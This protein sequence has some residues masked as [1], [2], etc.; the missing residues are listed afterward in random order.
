MEKESII[1]ATKVKVY[2]T[3][4]VES[5]GTGG[6]SHSNN[7]HRMDGEREAG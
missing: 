2:G 6:Q 4:N 5:D 3:E 7:A 1:D